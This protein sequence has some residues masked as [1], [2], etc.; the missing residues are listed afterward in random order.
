MKTICLEYK[1]ASLPRGSKSLAGEVESAA[2]RLYRKLKAEP[3]SVFKRNRGIYGR[4][5]GEHFCTLETKLRNCVY[6]V[7]WGVACASKP[8]EEVVLVDHGGGLGLIG[9]V[10]KELGVGTVIYN[11]L[12]QEFCHAAEDIAGIIGLKMDRYIHGDV[13][14]LI[15]GLEGPARTVPDVLVSYDVLEHIYDLDGFFAR[16]AVSACCPQAFFMSSGANMLSPR[17]VLQVRRIQADREVLNLAKRVGI[18]RQCAGGLTEA[19]VAGAPYR[20]SHIATLQ[21]AGEL[22]EAEVV[23]LAKGTRLLVRAEIEAVVKGY[24][25]SKTLHVPRKAGINGQDPFRSN[26]VDPESGWWAEHLVNPYSIAR[27]LRNQGFSAK[28]MPGFYGR[29]GAILNP[30]IRALGAPLALPLAAFYSI[31]A[32]K[33]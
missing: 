1:F 3:L 22:T 21:C 19:E 24:L 27:C 26:T 20:L 8:K 13:D 11:D 16:L 6:H 17:Y 9:L 7:V 29:R 14:A 31:R 28:V 4:F 10:A 30:V 2:Q 23:V 15:R 33:H 32:A 12:D 25:Q 18:I 5:I